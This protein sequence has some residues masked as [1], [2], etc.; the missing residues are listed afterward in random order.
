MV[1][2]FG[3]K[4][5]WP[6]LMPFQIITKVVSLN[7]YPEISHLPNDIHQICEMCFIPRTARSSA[8]DILRKLWSVHKLSE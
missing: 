5:V 4:P 1:E 3:E 8:V 7:Q 6:N 2:L